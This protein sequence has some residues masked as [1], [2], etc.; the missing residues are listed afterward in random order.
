MS[1][2]TLL[3]KKKPN[4]INNQLEGFFVFHFVL[5]HNSFLA[6]PHQTPKAITTF[7]ESITFDLSIKTI[8][9]HHSIKKPSPLPWYS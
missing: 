1:S 3:K 2:K 6:F 9:S 8:I 4:L 5:K 7:T